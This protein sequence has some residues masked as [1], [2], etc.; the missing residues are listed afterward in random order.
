MTHS[1]SSI[2]MTEIEKLIPNRFL[3]SVAVAKRARQLKEGY[4]PLIEINE[5]NPNP[6]LVA[7][8][9]IELGKLDIAHDASHDTDN[10]LLQ[11]MELDL[12]HEVSQ[13][14]GVGTD[15]KTDTKSKPKRRKTT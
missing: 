15:K 1:L 14:E 2:S 10:E 6:I 4:R 7:L 13:L 8:K 11:R 3:L 12:N 5:E 9:E